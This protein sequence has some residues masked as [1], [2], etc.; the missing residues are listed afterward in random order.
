M[1]AA[2]S[3]TPRILDSI[4]EVAGTAWNALDAGG[5]PFLR[6]EFLTALES[7]G[8][9]CEATGWIPRHVLLHDDQGRL[10]AAMPCYLKDHSWGEFV[11]DHAW[12]HA[13]ERSGREYYPKLVS[14]VPFTPISGPRL[15][16]AAGVDRNRAGAR[17]I[18]TARIAAV[19]EDASSLHILF[20]PPD[21]IAE[22]E[23]LGLSPRKDCQ[24]HWR[25]RDYACFDDFLARFRSDRRKKV[26]RERRRVSDA[27]I[28]FRRVEGDEITPAL[29]DQVYLMHAATFLERG[30]SPYLS[31][32]FFSQLHQDM[33]ESLLLILA[34][35]DG[36]PVACAICL[37]DDDTLY[38]RY[39]GCSERY[40]SLHFETCLYQGIDYSIEHGLA[41]FEPGAQGEHKLR[42]GFEPTATCSA[43]WLRDPVFATA[44]GNHLAL[45][46]QWLETY[47]RQSREQLPFRRDTESPH[48][49]TGAEPE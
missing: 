46:R 34:L 40:H 19:T 28:G 27:G 45:E 23:A 36:V 43:H 12:A 15:L 7:S 4:G 33:P 5:S 18:E 11:F 9:A 49:D 48:R 2:E 44:I 35:Q 21:T 47:L 24:Y 42:R 39:W 41:R 6:H 13:Y 10:L 3:A 38:G 37:R 20:P 16:V 14:C 25:N 1:S 26:R 30:Q 22:L 32:R 17:L 8:S 31:R 29:L